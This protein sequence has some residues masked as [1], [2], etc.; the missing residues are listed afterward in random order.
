[1]K[2]LVQRILQIDHTAKIKLEE[3]EQR[4]Q[5]TLQKIEEKKHALADSLSQRSK[6]YLTNAEENEAAAAKEAIDEI[7]TTMTAEQDRLHT[8]YLAN[9]Q[10][11]LD[12]L[13]SDII[14]NA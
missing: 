13:L 10:A 12:Q 11:Y 1:M 9:Q 2:D 7:Q 6:D 14:P 4:K 8:L 5:E 3:A